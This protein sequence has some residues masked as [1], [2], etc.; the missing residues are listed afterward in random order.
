MSELFT[1]VDEMTLELVCCI[2][3]YIFLFQ[4]HFTLNKVVANGLLFP[5]KTL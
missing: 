4:F 1:S 2:F 5:W 3:V